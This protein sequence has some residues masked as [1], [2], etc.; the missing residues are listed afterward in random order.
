MVLSE[1]TKIGSF[2]GL[3]NDCFGTFVGTEK[4]WRNDRLTR[5]TVTAP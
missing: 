2:G 5:G 1:V 3:E 4:I